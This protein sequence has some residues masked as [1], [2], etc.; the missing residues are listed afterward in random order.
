MTIINHVTTGAL[1]AVAINKPAVA[2]PA[3][4]LSHSAIDAIPHWDY[5]FKNVLHK[6]AAIMIDITLTLWL[7]FVLAILFRDSARLII[8]GGFLAIL[9]DAVWLPEVVQGKPIPMNRPTLLHYLR[10]LNAWFQWSEPPYGKY[11]EIA[12]FILTLASLIL[13]LR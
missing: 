3:A 13:V 9:P 1:V 5:K 4:L 7:T 6:Q 8:A 10:R 11:I 12:W 2:L